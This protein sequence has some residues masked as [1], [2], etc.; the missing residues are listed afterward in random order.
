M[1]RSSIKTWNTWDRRLRLVRRRSRIPVAETLRDT[2]S[3]LCRG[4]Q[5]GDGAGDH[6]ASAGSRACAGRGL[7]GQDHDITDR[8]DGP[9][10]PRGGPVSGPGEIDRGPADH[11]P[12]HAGPR[13]PPMH[14]GHLW[15][16]YLLLS[17][18]TLTAK[19]GLMETPL[20][21]RGWRRFWKAFDHHHRQSVP[22]AA[23]GP[24]SLVGL[25]PSDGFDRESPAARRWRGRFPV[26]SVTHVRDRRVAGKSRKYVTR[27]L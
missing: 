3:C 11:R 13:E 12:H 23:L 5:L 22:E 24:G 7:K 2:A 20:S 26:L 1:R 4:L 17:S 9:P 27:K 19:S 14:L 15:Y 18:Q 16:R 21:M 25:R 8:G 10:S 6:G